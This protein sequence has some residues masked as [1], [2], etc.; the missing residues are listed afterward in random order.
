MDEYDD[1]A[2]V[3]STSNEVTSRVDVFSVGIVAVSKNVQSELQSGGK[4][5]RGSHAEM[6]MTALISPISS[7]SISHPFLSSEPTILSLEDWLGDKVL[8]KGEFGW[9]SSFVFYARKPSNP[10]H[11]I[12]EGSHVNEAF[13]NPTGKHLNFF[14]LWARAT[15]PKTPFLPLPKLPTGHFPP[16]MW[17]NILSRRIEFKF[18]SGDHNRSLRSP[19][20]F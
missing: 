19:P 7:D 2:N 9:R 20:T 3:R 13:A 6:L 17:Y 11:A 1:I 14:H 18:I 8:S 12:S 16:G 4:R 15:P 5:P 10:G